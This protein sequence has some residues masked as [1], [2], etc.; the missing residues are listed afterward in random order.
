[1]VYNQS[2][3]FSVTNAQGAFLLGGT[4]AQSPQLRGNISTN[5]LFGQTES[6][7]GVVAG[8]STP[9]AGTSYLVAVNLK[10]SG[11]SNSCFIGYG[12]AGGTFAV[13]TRGNPSVNYQNASGALDTLFGIA[14]AENTSRLFGEPVVCGVLP[15]YTAANE[16]VFVS[17]MQ[18]ILDD[19]Y[20]KFFGGASGSAE[21]GTFRG[22]SR[23][24]GT[25]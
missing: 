24:I 11:G 16:S 25:R 18:G 1:M 6:A 23:G 15:G 4:T 2:D 21:R 7:G 19:P 13:Q 3:T 22:I 20:G 5:V 8:T 17:D 9:G 10:N 12:A 14:G